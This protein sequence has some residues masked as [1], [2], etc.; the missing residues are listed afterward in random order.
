MHFL[1]RVISLQGSVRGCHESLW[2]Y[3]NPTP[4]PT[5]PPPPVDNHQFA[6]GRQIQQPFLITHDPAC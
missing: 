1:G 6:V 5:T 3:C 4:T 2:L